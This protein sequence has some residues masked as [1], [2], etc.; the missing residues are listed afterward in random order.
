MTPMNRLKLPKISAYTARFGGS[1]QGIP[2]PTGHRAQFLEGLRA[3][4]IH[5]SSTLYPPPDGDTLATRPMI[6]SIDIEQ[7]SQF[8][9]LRLVVL[10]VVSGIY[11]LSILLSS[12]HD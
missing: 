7:V 2:Y 4:A 10:V 12:E 3:H 5:S 11:P 6:L 9:I 8:L 1:P